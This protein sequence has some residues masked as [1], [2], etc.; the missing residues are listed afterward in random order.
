MLFL[1]EIFNWGNPRKENQGGVKKKIEFNKR[2]SRDIT[3]GGFC[4]EDVYRQ[5]GR[6]G[7]A[8]PGEDVSSGKRIF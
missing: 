7:I 4:P 8:R 5:T 2:F 6:V 3:T 1:R